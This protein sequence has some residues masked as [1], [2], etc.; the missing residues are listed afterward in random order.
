[1]LGNISGDLSAD[2]SNIGRFLLQT[3]WRTIFSYC[4]GSRQ[5]RRYRTISRLT[6]LIFK[7]GHWRH[8]FQFAFVT[9]YCHRLHCPVIL[10]HIVFTIW[11]WYSWYWFMILLHWVTHYLALELINKWGRLV[12]EEMREMCLEGRP[13]VGLDA[14]RVLVF[15]RFIRAPVITCYMI[16]EYNELFLPAIKIH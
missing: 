9:W 14:T 1:M 10:V 12:A 5:K 4:I 2:I 15:L 16:P 13:L 7:R 3:I 11:H 8:L 6:R